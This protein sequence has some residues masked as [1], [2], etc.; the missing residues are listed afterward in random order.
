MSNISIK[1]NTVY[2]IFKACCSVIFPL[3]TFPYISRVLLPENV[4]KV[5]FSLNIVNYFSLLASLGV[6]VYAI[7]EC[8]RVRDD[9]DALS[10]VASEIF[11]INFC[12]TVVS[13]AL[14]F[15]SLIFVPQFQ[16]YRML[17]AVQSINILLTTLGADWLNSA[18]EDFR[19]VTLRSF[20]CQLISLI[21]MFLFVK[22]GNDYFIYAV[23][24][25]VASTGANFMNIFYRG[26]FCRVRLVKQMN[27]KHHFP[28]IFQLFVMQLAQVV[29][30]NADITMLGL[31]RSDYEVGLYTAAIR[32]YTYVGQLM[33][34][35]LW[36]VMPRLSMY[37]AEKDYD[38]IN[39]LLRKIL[40]YLVALGLP[41]VVGICAMAPEILMVIGGEEYLAAVPALRILMIALLFSLF[42]GSFIGNVIMLTSNR[43]KIFLVV[44]CI[45][46]V[47]N[48]V[49][50][51]L[52]IP[53]FGIT[54]AAGTTA[55]SSL[56]IFVLLLPKVEKQIKIGNYVSVFLLP[57]IGCALIYLIVCLGQWFIEN[58]WIRILVTIPCSVAAY[59]VVL[60][61]GKYELAQSVI[62]PILAR[63]R[64]GDS[65]A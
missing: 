27:W 21:A 19:Y 61:I 20:A 48:V 59:G 32:I 33:A 37:Y 60:L 18:V 46:A 17:I 51:G 63:F 13:Y 8:A 40:C 57:V 14:L 53:F 22:N 29:F 25:V 10:R 47:V 24:G 28:P 1:K 56:L 45:T 38:Q 50:N 43:E 12:L 52:L 58:T 55:F 42:G 30:S 49:L 35:I 65:N 7:R 2:S 36:V 15:L 62:T 41:C 54:A 44:C 3:I 23:I 64:K 31:M 16:D 6:S 34:S 4:G 26:R 39:P 5:S 9:K 11:S